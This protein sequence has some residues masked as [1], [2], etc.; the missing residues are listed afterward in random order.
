[1]L[2]LCQGGCYAHDCCAM[3][4]TPW[5]PCCA[6]AARKSACSPLLLRLHHGTFALP[7][8]S[9]IPSPAPRIVFVSAPFSSGRTFG[10]AGRSSPPAIVNP[11]IL[12]ASDSGD[13]TS[14]K[15]SDTKTIVGALTGGGL[16][17]DAV[18]HAA[19]CPLCGTAFTGTT[20]CPSSA[21]DAALLVFQM[22]P[23]TAHH[24]SSELD[25]KNGQP[26]LPQPLLHLWG[27]QLY[28]LTDISRLFCSHVQRAIRSDPY[29]MFLVSCQARS[30]CPPNCNRA[31]P[32]LLRD[33]VATV[34]VGRPTS[35]WS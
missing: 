16:T 3:H 28:H 1:M 20:L 35:A 29:D 34:E 10:G 23:V 14:S 24:F 21:S 12:T 4:D 27:S 25:R 30:Y 33:P 19:C 18:L 17:A 26:L 8:A 31:T 9:A 7:S 22:M 6:L 5:H 15:P 2:P 11:G 13:R 32:P